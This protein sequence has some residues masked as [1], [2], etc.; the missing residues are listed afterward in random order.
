[1]KCCP[2]ASITDANV[3]PGLAADRHAFSA[4]AR[5]RTKHAAGAALTSQAVTAETRIGP[6]EVVAVSCPQLQ[7]A[8]RDDMAG[9]GAAV[10][11][12]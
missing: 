3:L 1:V 11:D 5:L 7:G 8:L 4:K 12:V 10:S 6:S 2:T 9:S